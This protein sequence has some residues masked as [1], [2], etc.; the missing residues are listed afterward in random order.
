MYC[1]K[2][3]P[4]IGS[5]TAVHMAL[6]LLAPNSTHKL[7]SR[8][9]PYNKDKEKDNDKDNDRCSADTETRT[10]ISIHKIQLWVLPYNKD[11]DKSDTETR[12]GRYCCTWP[13][14]SPIN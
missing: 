4:H 11:E 9:L 10:E 2:A 3:P 12:R 8:V 6:I 14:T 5:L 13:L 1:T 7:Q